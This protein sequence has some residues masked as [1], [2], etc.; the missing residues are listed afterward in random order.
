MPDVV[1]S[2]RTRRRLREVAARLA[3]ADA[4]L[5]VA[6]HGLASVDPD[7]DEAR[8]RLAAWSRALPAGGFVATADAG[9]R[10]A[11]AGFGP[12][13]ILEWHGPD[14]AAQHARYVDWLIGVRGRRIV[15]L[16]CGVGRGL[17]T[18][19]R[20][21]AR[22]AGRSTAELVRIH[23]AGSEH[24]ESA[25]VL[26]LPVAEALRRLAAALPP[27][28]AERCDESLPAPSTIPGGLVG[29][30]ALAREADAATLVDLGRGVV[31]VLAG[32]TPPRDAIRACID[33]LLQAREAWV[34]V[35]ALD[36]E[37]PPGYRFTA[38][39]V[40]G[41]EERHRQRRPGGLMLFFTGPD[42]DAIM[43]VGVARSADVAGGLWRILH[44]TAQT[45]LAPLDCPPPPWVARRPDPQAGRHEPVQPALLRFARTAAW[46]W[47][48]CQAM[49]DRTGR[50]SGR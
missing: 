29:L 9:R 35:A 24:D 5:V 3:R 8:R 19:R 1:V 33:A 2:D 4:L 23:P 43:T 39:A 18:L 15:V 32:A 11:A 21:G 12:G 28:F 36:G 34:P 10:F 27:E 37:S 16:E 25:T 30:E 42:D 40:F 47:L 22:V 14:Q 50:G 49:L 41:S 13:R 44:E 6:G 20:I 48:A 45:R 17:T 26:R 31:D 46:A 7:H 38:R